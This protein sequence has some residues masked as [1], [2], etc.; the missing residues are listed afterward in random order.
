MTTSKH[1]G[2]GCDYV[3]T[4]RKPTCPGLQAELVASVTDIKLAEGRPALKRQSQD[5]S[6]GLLGSPAQGTGVWGP[7]GCGA[8]SHCSWWGEAGGK[9]QGP[10]GQS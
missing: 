1:K 10:R 6:S 7:G 8:S 4:Q 3:Q 2:G 5:S 9:T